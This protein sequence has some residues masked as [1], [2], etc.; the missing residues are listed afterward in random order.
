M[1]VQDVHPLTAEEKQYERRLAQ[2]APASHLGDDWRNCWPDHIKGRK[3]L[4]YLSE[5]GPCWSLEMLIQ[6]AEERLTGPEAVVFIENISLPWTIVLGSAWN[7][8]PK[9]FTEHVRPLDDDDAELTLRRCRV[10]NSRGGLPSTREQ[11]WATMRRYVDLG[12]PQRPLSGSDLEDTTKRRHDESV[13]ATRQSHTNLPFYRVNETL[14]TYKHLFA[15]EHNADKIVPLVLFLIDHVPD[16]RHHFVLDHLKWFP[17]QPVAR[18]G[19]VDSPGYIAYPRL[20]WTDV[21]AVLPLFTAFQDATNREVLLRCLKDNAIDEFLYRVVVFQCERE[22][23]Y[24]SLDIEGI[25]DKQAEG[26][27]MS[28]SD[29]LPNIQKALT[30]LKSC[31]QENRAYEDKLRRAGFVNTA[32]YPARTEFEKL[33][34]RFSELDNSLVQCF[35]RQMTTLTAT[36]TR[37]NLRQTTATNK[38]AQA[39]YE[40]TRS[41]S[42]LTWLA[43]FYVPLT[44]V[45]GIFGMNVTEIDPEKPL[46]WRLYAVV[47]GGFLLVSVLVVVSYRALQKCWMRRMTANQ[48]EWQRSPPL[49][50]WGLKSSKTSSSIELRSRQHV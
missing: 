38:Q 21:V 43:F 15:P 25:N 31:I 39:T 49:F 45:T 24:I 5:R 37:G 22:A 33:A 1:T 8:E 10:P 19:M 23:F 14:C 12:K 9:F 42:T 20:G 44:F 48:S 6:R 28:T 46:S 4:G 36:G 17:N 50:R 35:Y 41:M 13:F 16:F 26:N 18:I 30:R 2:A 27:G 34:V 11:C 32:N 47:A 40:Q 29:S 3:P 7:L